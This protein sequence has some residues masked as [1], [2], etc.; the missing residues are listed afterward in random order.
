MS[1]AAIYVTASYHRWLNWS[2]TERASSDAAAAGAKLRVGGVPAL[3]VAMLHFLQ[4][5][6]SA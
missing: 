4:A 3:E 5:L 1:G 6:A 2:D